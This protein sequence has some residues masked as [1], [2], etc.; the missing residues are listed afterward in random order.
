MVIHQPTSGSQ[1]CET[2]LERRRKENEGEERSLKDIFQE[3]CITNRNAC[4]G[5]V[6]VHESDS[7]VAAPKFQKYLQ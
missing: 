3:I 4:I 5:Q 6:P 1:C 7:A 2:D